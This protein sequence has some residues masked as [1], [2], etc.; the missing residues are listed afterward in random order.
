M[1]I[2]GDISVPAKRMVE[3][4]VEYMNAYGEWDR[5]SVPESVDEHDAR[6]KVDPRAVTQIEV[7]GSTI[8]VTG[9]FTVDEVV[10]TIGA[11]R[12]NPPEYITEPVEMIFSIELHLQ[13]V[14]EVSGIID[15]A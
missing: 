14:P 2:H 6:K 9:E 3:F 13:D 7:D 11:T 12:I 8:I 15:Y 4:V 5:I 1:P 10:D